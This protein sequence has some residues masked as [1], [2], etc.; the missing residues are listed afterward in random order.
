MSDSNGAKSVVTITVRADGLE[1]Q[2]D[3]KHP[4]DVA[5]ILAAALNA[6]LAPQ[7]QPSRLVQPHPSGLV[8]V[9]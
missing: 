7:P 4:I 9:Q 6:T 5:R 1:I 2:S 3:R 8:V